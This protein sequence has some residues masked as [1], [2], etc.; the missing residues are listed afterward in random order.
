[1]IVKL[2]TSFLMPAELSET[3]SKYVK[4]TEEVNVQEPYVLKLLGLLKE[5]V[6]FL[7]KS[8]TRQRANSKIDSLNEA[9]AVRDDLLIAFRDL[10]DIGKRRQN[11]AIVE[12]YQLTWPVLESTGLRIYR[13]GQ[14][15]K[16]GKL[17]A[18]FE[19]LDQSSY[20]EALTTLNAA[21]LYAELKTAEAQYLAIYSERVIEDGDRDTP[22]MEEAKRITVPHVNIFLGVLSTLE[23]FEPEVYDALSVRIN[24][25]TAEIMTIARARKTRNEAP[26]NGQNIV[27]NDSPLGLL[28][29]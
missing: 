19:V 6:S 3:T 14:T 15:E 11:P 27:F 23:V 20:Q 28:T 25:I 21:E 13:L 9:D 17:A 1:M 12:A 26:T 24:S 16:S 18:L 10:I 22:T 29:S 5:D 7:N 2:R 8:L 4:A